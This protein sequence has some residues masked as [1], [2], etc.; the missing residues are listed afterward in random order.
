M[1]LGFEPTTFG[2][3]VSF[4][5]DLTRSYAQVFAI[6]YDANVFWEEY[7]H[8]GNEFEPLIWAGISAN[9]GRVKTH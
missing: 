3:R 5:N 2:T 4:H 8:L 1:V 7:S 6:T 9:F